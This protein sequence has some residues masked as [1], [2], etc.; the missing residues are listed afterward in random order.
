M[1]LAPKG[2]LMTVIW[3]S[4]CPAEL[5]VTVWMPARLQSPGP[6]ALPLLA[7]WVTTRDVPGENPVAITRT[8]AGDFNACDG[9][10]VN[11]GPPDAAPG[12]VVGPGGAVV[13]VGC[14]LVP[15]LALLLQAA[16]LNPTA[17]AN[18]TTNDRL[19]ITIT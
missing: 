19:L 18:I 13:V 9:V 4:T 7:H 1:W 11:C 8:V 10:I 17:K 3:V 12:A 5:A 2:P 16:R 15:L 14:E 6:V